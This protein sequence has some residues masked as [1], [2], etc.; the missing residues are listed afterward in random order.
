MT[1]PPRTQKQ[2]HESTLRPP[3]Y[4]KKS[5]SAVERDVL[6][7]IHKALDAKSRGRFWNIK[8][9]KGDMLQGSKVM[10]ETGDE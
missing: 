7:T 3:K 1:D 4:D 9:G 8:G 2:E 6:S 10:W 5:E